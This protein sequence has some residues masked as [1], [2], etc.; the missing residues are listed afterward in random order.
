[1]LKNAT[2]AAATAFMDAGMTVE[3]FAKALEFANGDI[4]FESKDL[5]KKFSDLS[6][7]LK[8][9]AIQDALTAYVSGGKTEEDKAKRLA[10]VSSIGKGFSNVASKSEAQAMFLNTR[11][12]AAQYYDEATVSKIMD[13]AKSAGLFDKTTT[14]EGPTRNIAG[15]SVKERQIVYDSAA[16][17]RYNEAVS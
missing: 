2:G 10:E 11:T 17:Q 16:A 14:Q 7:S 9:P 13:S 12:T 8:V 1:M 5:S 15:R 4:V 3:G 6:S